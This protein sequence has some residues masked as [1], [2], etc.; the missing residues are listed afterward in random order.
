[1]GGGTEGFGSLITRIPRMEAS[2]DAD[3]MLTS[4]VGSN[5][6]EEASRAFCNY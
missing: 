1:L 4:C 5:G 3:K 2:H 6:R